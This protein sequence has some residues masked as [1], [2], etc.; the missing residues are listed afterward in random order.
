MK[1]VKLA[2][3]ILLIV[4]STSIFSSCTRESFDYSATAKEFISKGQWSVDLFFAGQ[5][6]T[7]QYSGYQFTFTGNGTVTA[8][9][10][11]ETIEGIWSVVTDVN[12]NEV[13]Q[14]NMNSQDPHIQEL[15]VHWS[16]TDKNNLF[17]AMKDGS[18]ELRFKKL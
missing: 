1:S 16:V 7:A 13:L 6:K 2:L 5:D 14:I 17:I 18:N 11:V 10:T 8:T 3:S 15:N 9:N 12:R 4:I